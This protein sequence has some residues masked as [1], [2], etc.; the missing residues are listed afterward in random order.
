MLVPVFLALLLGVLRGFGFSWRRTYL[1]AALSIVTFS[2]VLLAMTL[3][4]ELLATCFLYA[5]ILLL[6]CSVNV[7]G[8]RARWWAL[9]GGL[10]AGLAYLTRN[11]LL[12][13]FPAALLFFWLRKRFRL[14]LFFLAFSLPM[15]AGW[16]AWT[17]AHSGTGFFDPI[18]GG[19]FAEYLRILH[20]TGFWANF[21][22]Q[23]AAIS[24]SVAEQ[25]FPGLTGALGGLPLYHL[26]FAAAIAGA[27]RIGQ[28]RNWPL[29]LL[30]AGPYL[31]LIAV[32][33]FDGVGRLLMPIW[34]VLVAGIAE[35]ASHFATLCEKS[36]ARWKR[37][38]RGAL[39][40]AGLLLVARSDRL[41]WSRAESVVA[42]ERVLGIEDEKV[43]A[44]VTALARP[45]TVVAT[46]K[47]SVVFL[48]TGLPASH[49]LF[50]T[51][52]PQ[53][54]GKAF[55]APF[56]ALPPNLQRCLMVILRSDFSDDLGD[57]LMSSL[58]DLGKSLAGSTLEFSSPNALIYS[59]PIA[60]LREA[61]LTRSALRGT[62]LP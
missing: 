54:G 40:A 52:N 49:G 35:E 62:T 31:L 39:I 47:D 56:S 23:V 61:E 37:A 6:E 26:V 9:G 38:P 5:A 32:W 58:R 43:L 13:I 45:D 55:S 46:W 59:F 48:Y 60:P 44:Q 21:V 29:A 24:G 34:P 10:L 41:T 2:M 53:I 11:A 36:M 3:F 16:H 1:V 28:K 19:Y 20:A 4:S 14:S 7:A 33:W 17:L 22:K 57:Q 50:A 15:A 25:F 18:Y 27:L 51:I 12:P 8:P 30:F 42:K